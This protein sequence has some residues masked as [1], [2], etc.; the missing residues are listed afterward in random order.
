MW[1][2]AAVVREH[3]RLLYEQSGTSREAL[4]PMRKHLIW[5][6]RGV[7]GKAS[8]RELAQRIESPDDVEAWVRALETAMADNPGAQRS[9]AA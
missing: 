4:L 5:Y 2:R 6:A 7:A 8:L 9:S 1:S 3:A